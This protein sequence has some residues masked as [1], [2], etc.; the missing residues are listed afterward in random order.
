[1]V[2]KPGIMLV[3]GACET[4]IPHGVYLASVFE[5]SNRHDS[6]DKAIVIPNF[7]VYGI[8]NYPWLL[9]TYQE[10]KN[11]E[12]KQVDHLQAPIICPIH[13]GISF[14]RSF[15]NSKNSP[16]VAS[17]KLVTCA[18]LK[19]GKIIMLPMFKII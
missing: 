6:E 10:W 8:K 1:M 18:R 15:I 13:T 17:P 2:F 4:N 16:F 7:K 11:W 3:S 14:L 12:L 9:L 19:N 5:T